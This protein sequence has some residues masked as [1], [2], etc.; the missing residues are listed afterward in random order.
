MPRAGAFLLATLAALAA[1][2]FAL[3]RT[4]NGIYVGVL[5]MLFI[6]VGI[7]CLLFAVRGFLVA[8]PRTSPSPRTR[9][10]VLFHVCAVFGALVG[11]GIYALARASDGPFA[12]QAA[13]LIIIF[14]VIIYLIK[15]TVAIVAAV[16]QLYVRWVITKF[17]RKH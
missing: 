12:S 3:T 11:A 4:N 9:F 8:I 7:P 14:P 1:I 6:F 15:P 13:W 17:S 5:F 2:Y 10:S 16:F